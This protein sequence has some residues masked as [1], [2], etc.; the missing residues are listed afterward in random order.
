[1]LFRRLRGLSTHHIHAAHI[2]DDVRQA[3]TRRVLVNVPQVYEHALKG[4][5]PND[6]LHNWRDNNHLHKPEPSNWIEEATR[7]THTP[8]GVQQQHHL[9]LTAW[10]TEI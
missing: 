6:T 4:N 3:I 9:W 5:G 10:A 2:L 8:K 1:M 7:H